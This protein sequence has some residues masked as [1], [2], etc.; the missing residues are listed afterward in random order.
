MDIIGKTASAQN[1]E[2]DTRRSA[3]RGRGVKAVS[4]LSLAIALYG[5]AGWIYVALCAL[6]APDTLKLP[7]THLLPSLREDTSGVISFVFSFV[8]FLIYR[9]TRPD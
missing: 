1:T 7:L 4:E 5:M 6:T 3:K 9:L 8:G 2:T